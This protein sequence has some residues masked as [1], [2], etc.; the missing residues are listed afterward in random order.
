MRFLANLL[1]LNAFV[2]P[3]YFL[4]ELA[5]APIGLWKAS[6]LGAL[7]GFLAAVL[8]REP[9]RVRPLVEYL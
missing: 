3:W 7:V 8:S 5:G 4:F 9:P 1:V 6:L 2:S